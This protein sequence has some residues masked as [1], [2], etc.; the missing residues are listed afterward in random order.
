RQRTGSGVDHVVA[1]TWRM[2]DTVTRTACSPALQP[3][4]LPGENR[5]VEQLD[6]AAVERGQEAQVNLALALLCR[7]ILRDTMRSEPLARPFTGIPI[8]DNL[9]DAVA[10]EQNRELRHDIVR[11]ERRT[12]LARQIQHRTL[13]RPVI[14]PDAQAHTVA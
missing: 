13:R 6:L 11:A 1:R 5:V 3:D 10:L 14:V 7:L 9:A 12:P 2:V 4:Q 8:T